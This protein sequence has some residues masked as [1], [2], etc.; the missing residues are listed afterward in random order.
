MGSFGIAPDNKNLTFSNSLFDLY[1]VTQ[2]S[3]CFGDSEGYLVLG[4]EKTNEMFTIANSVDSLMI[5]KTG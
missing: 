3:I 5:M 2:F 1:G 4:N